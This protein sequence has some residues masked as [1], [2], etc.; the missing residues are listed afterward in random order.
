VGYHMYLVRDDNLTLFELG[1]IQTGL[2]NVFDGLR[3]KLN[4]F[5]LSDPEI[6]AELLL[7]EMVDPDRVK[8]WPQPKD[9]VPVAHALAERMVKW[10]AGKPLACV[11]E[12]CVFRRQV[13]YPKPPE[14]V[15][16]PRAADHFVTTDSIHESEWPYYD[17]F[18]KLP[19]ELWP[20]IYPRNFTPSTLAVVMY[21]RSFS[22]HCYKRLKTRDEREQFLSEMAKLEPLTTNRDCGYL[23]CPKCGPHDHSPEVAGP[24]TLVFCGCDCHIEPVVCTGFHI[25]CHEINTPREQQTPRP[26][27][28]PVK[29][30]IGDFNKFTFPTIRP[31]G[32]FPKLF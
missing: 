4:Y 32:G 11:G 14:R 7:D 8:F 1:K 13:V 22:L 5:V 27:S 25:C 16:R 20:Q 24:R 3:D 28:K 9:Y 21:V 15:E 6:L 30:Q 23:G 17:V 26:P 12:N 10:G 2:H 19:P 31:P 18:Q 29:S